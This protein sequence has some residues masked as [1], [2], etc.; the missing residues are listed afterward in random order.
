MTEWQLRMVHNRYFYHGIPGIQHS[1]TRN[2]LLPTNKKYTVQDLET[3]ASVLCGKLIECRSNMDSRS[4][5]DWFGKEG[6]SENFASEAHSGDVLVQLVNCH[7]T[8]NPVF[9]ITSDYLALY[10]PC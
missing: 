8:S 1:W 9:G 10:L 4:S 2:V 3:K 6:L 7:K 5:G